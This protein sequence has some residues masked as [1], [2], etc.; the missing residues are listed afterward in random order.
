M[1]RQRGKDLAGGLIQPG[2]TLTSETLPMNAPPDLMGSGDS[3]GAARERLT[4]ID[5]LVRK[6]GKDGAA[7]TLRGQGVT[8]DVARQWVAFYQNEAGKFLPGAPKR[9][10]PRAEARL[11]VAQR[12][13]EI[14][15]G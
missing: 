10:Q 4:W 13:I 3:I 15:G 6:Q 2:G 11:E 14:L 1:A 8:T 7:T 12:V 9:Q 5:Q